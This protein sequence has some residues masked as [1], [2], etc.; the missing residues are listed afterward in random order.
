MWV[1]EMDIC[2]IHFKVYRCIYRICSNITWGKYDCGTGLQLIIQLV[3]FK[4]CMSIYR[5]ISNKIYEKYKYGTIL[6][7]I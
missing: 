3:Y 1:F 2:H 5:I 4:I 6:K 7:L